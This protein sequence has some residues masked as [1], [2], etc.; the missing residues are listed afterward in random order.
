MLSCPESPLF[1]H[2]E[3]SS[4]QAF[5]DHSHLGPVQSL[6]VAPR[7]AFP[8]FVGELELSADVFNLFNTNN[9]P[10]FANAATTSNQIQLGAVWKF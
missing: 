4:L 9:E 8:A 1:W 3:L 7:R 5:I 2:L 6:Q 10:G